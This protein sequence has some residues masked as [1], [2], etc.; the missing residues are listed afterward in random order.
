MFRCFRVELVYGNRCVRADATTVS[1]A[2]HAEARTAASR[3]NTSEATGTYVPDTPGT[4]TQGI[5]TPG[6]LASGH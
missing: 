1:A 2:K 5:G 4:G 3:N 6:P